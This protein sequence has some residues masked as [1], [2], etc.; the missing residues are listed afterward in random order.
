[1]SSTDVFLALIGGLAKHAEHP[2]KQV[3]ACVYCDTCGV[4]LYQGEALT[5]QEKAELREA[6]RATDEKQ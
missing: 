3:G 2:W 6:V 4:R 1:M 5:E